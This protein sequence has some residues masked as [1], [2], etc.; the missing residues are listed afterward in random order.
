MR[1]ERAADFIRPA[2]LVSFM[3]SQQNLSHGGDYKPGLNN[4]AGRLLFSLLALSPLRHDECL[5]HSKIS[6]ILHNEATATVLFY[7]NSAWGH[8]L[9][10][11]E[12]T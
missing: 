7:M 6:S 3:K 12:D 2:N 4:T 10:C 11:G 9:C 1:R 5:I 8:I